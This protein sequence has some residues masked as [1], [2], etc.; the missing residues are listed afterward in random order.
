[1]LT[2]GTKATAA[3]SYSVRPPSPRPPLSERQNEVN[4]DHAVR[5]D[6]ERDYH[7]V[8]TA[9]HSYSLTMP[10]WIRP[11]APNRLRN[12]PAGI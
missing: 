5:S 9:D 10:L 6:D 11:I 2:K 3:R 1:M 8:A 7:D 4:Q 12:Q